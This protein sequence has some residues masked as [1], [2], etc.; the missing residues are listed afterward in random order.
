MP[1]LPQPLTQPQAFTI[2]FRGIANALVDDTV[3]VSVPYDPTSNDPHPGVKRLCAIWD[4]GASASVITE[5]VVSEL[6]LQPIDKTK[7]HTANG[8]RDAYV[9]LVNIYLRNNVAFPVIRVTDGDIPGSNIDLLIG[10]D[11]IRRGDFAVTHSEGR[12][13]MSF[14][15]P[16]HRKIDFVEDL[17]QR[18]KDI[19]RS[20]SRSQRN[21]EKAARRKKQGK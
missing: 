3:G 9:Y 17:E 20:M 11:I 19:G 13:C 4:T 6:G 5:R 7:V 1:P 10:L 2:E 12:T 15:L 21:K 18:S 16:S 14:Q 8:V